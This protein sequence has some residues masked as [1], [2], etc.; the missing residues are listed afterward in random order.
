R[1]ARAGAGPEVRVDHVVGRWAP[2]GPQGHP[3]DLDPTLLRAGDLDEPADHPAGE[4]ADR[5]DLLGAVGRRVEVGRHVDVRVVQHGRVGDLAGAVAGDA[6]PGVDQE[7]VG[8]GP[9]GVG[10]AVLVVGVGAPRVPGAVGLGAGAD[11]GAVA[12][13]RWPQVQGDLGEGLV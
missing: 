8:D 6:G 12:V 10:Q 4:L 5:R 11:E 2:G 13:V 9:A 3:V 7:R 1:D